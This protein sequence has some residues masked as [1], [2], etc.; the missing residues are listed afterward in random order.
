[1]VCLSGLGLAEN[2]ADRLWAREDQIGPV[3]P[4]YETRETR[5]V[6]ALG[7]DREGDMLVLAL[8]DVALRL[9]LDHA[10]DSS[11]KGFPSAE[12]LTSWASMSSTHFS[13]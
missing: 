8:E 11:S 3:T 2:G 10:R 13:L 5:V 6:D 1:M 7:I 4:G 12:S 9:F